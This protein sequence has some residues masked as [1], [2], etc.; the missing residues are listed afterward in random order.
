MR[1]DDTFATKLV[2]A[3]W[4]CSCLF[5]V[6]GFGLIVLGGSVLVCIGIGG[7]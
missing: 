6:I 4:G 2:R 5:V 1:R 7:R 3:G